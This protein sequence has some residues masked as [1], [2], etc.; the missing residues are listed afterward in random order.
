MALVTSQNK[1]EFDRAELAKRSGEKEEMKDPQ[2]YKHYSEQAE[3]QSDK[4]SDN[5]SHYDA[6]MS[7]KHAAIYAHP[8]PI[9]KKHEE[10]AKYHASEMRNAKKI[11]IE[12]HA[13]EFMK[14]KSDKNTKE[15]IKKG[16][17]SK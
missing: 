7:H 8:D 17:I 4:A 14:N 6:M 11:E 9:Y 15:M 1:A 12:K 10:K 2:L 5:M 3:N 13:E 16:L